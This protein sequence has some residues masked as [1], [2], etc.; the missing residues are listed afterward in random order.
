M[1][2]AVIMMCTLADYPGA[3]TG[4]T[5]KLFRALDSFLK[6]THPEKELILVSDGC[7]QTSEI[8]FKHYSKFSEIK[9]I[10]APKQPLK[11]P[12]F[13]RGLGLFYTD[14]ETISYLD[15]D[16]YLAPSFIELAQNQ[17]IQS[18][19]EMVYFD[20][21][22]ADPDCKFMNMKEITDDEII[23]DLQRHRWT[24][25]PV[26]FKERLI[27]TANICHKS[28]R[29]QPHLWHNWDGF[30]PPSEDW[31]FISEYKK[32]LD[33]LGKKPIQVDALGYYICHYPPDNVD[34]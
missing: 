28:G 23:L 22:T 29:W 14:A 25:V 33:C 31:A 17:L 9:H 34:V 3:A 12:G 13:L 30:T 21:I 26:T 6:N 27:G 24:R 15:A 4:R 11:Y 2:H 18:G 32:A 1:K 19:S 20:T 7:E 5:Q 8:Y 16:D 10:G